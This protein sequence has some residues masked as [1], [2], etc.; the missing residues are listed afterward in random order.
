MLSVLV[1]QTKPYSRYA[2]EDIKVPISYDGRQIIILESEVTSH[3][4]CV[5]VY[6]DC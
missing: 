4:K 1:A 3:E 5:S 2:Y 6:P